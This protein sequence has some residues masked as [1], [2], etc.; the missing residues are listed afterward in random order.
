MPASRP[1]RTKRLPANFP[2]RRRSSDGLRRRR[3][4]AQRTCL[5]INREPPRRLGTRGPL[6]LM[7]RQPTVTTPV[8]RRTNAGAIQPSEVHMGAV[9]TTL[10]RATPIPRDL[11]DPGLVSGWRCGG[12][13]KRWKSG[14][15]NRP[16]RLA[17]IL[18]R[19][20]D[21]SNARVVNAKG[22]HTRT[23]RAVH[24]I[25]RQSGRGVEYTQVLRKS[26]GDPIFGV[27]SERPFSYLLVPQTYAA[28]SGYRPSTSSVTTTRL[29]FCFIY[30]IERAT[31]RGAQRDCNVA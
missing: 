13:E 24:E 11:A 30:I 3:P 2:Q 29:R 18:G 12:W 10:G 1:D 15:V 8:R 21:S 6:G 25:T 17:L 28:S 22:L 19:A 7:S 5:P 4:R 23:W 9:E 27:L 26:G 20:L 31:R 16:G 14:T